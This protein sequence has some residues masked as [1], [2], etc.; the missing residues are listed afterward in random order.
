V[1]LSDS[2]NWAQGASGGRDVYDTSPSGLGITPSYLAGGLHVTTPIASGQVFP[3]GP[4]AG[5]TFVYIADSVN[6][7]RWTFQYNPIDGSGTYPWECVGAQPLQASVQTSDTTAG[8]SYGN[9]SFGISPTI[10]VPVAG[11]YDI[12]HGCSAS[13]T[14]GGVA[15]ASVVFSASAAS[16]NDAVRNG[17]TTDASIWARP[18]V[19]TITVAG[20]SVSQKYRVSAGTGTFADRRIL[21]W[22]RRVTG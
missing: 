20:Q 14:G 7:V 17:A 12:E 19:K 5:Q 13:C 18:S 11:V 9:L 3:V 16:D 8:T 6:L 10:I 22:P 4:T 1:S 21:V 2:L 15:R